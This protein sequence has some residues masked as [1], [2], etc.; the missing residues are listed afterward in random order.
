MTTPFPDFPVWVLVSDD[1]PGDGWFGEGVLR[2]G[3]G[4]PFMLPV[5]TTADKARR[6]AKPPFAPVPIDRWALRD[7]L[8]RGGFASV[9]VDVRTQG[10]DV[11]PADWVLSEIKVRR[12]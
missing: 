11:Y 4:P 8:E 7:L 3:D 5:Y 6:C 9:G 10:A 12:D 1:R 2:I